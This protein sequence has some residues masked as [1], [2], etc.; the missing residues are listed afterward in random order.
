MKRT[1][2]SNAVLSAGL[3]KKSKEQPSPELDQELEMRGG[4]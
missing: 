1:K 3:G 4:E 2:N